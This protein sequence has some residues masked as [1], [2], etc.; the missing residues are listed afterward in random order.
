ME[1]AQAAHEP[2]ER[3]EVRLSIGLFERHRDQSQARRRA[4]AS[5]Q[6]TGAAGRRQRALGF[7]PDCQRELSTPKEIARA[8]NGHEG[9]GTTSPHQVLPAAEPKFYALRQ[10]ASL[11]GANAPHPATLSD[12]T[13]AHYGQLPSSDWTFSISGQRIDLDSTYPAILRGSWLVLSKPSYQEL[14]RASSVT[15]AA[16]AEFHTGRKNH[17]HRTRYQ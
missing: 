8:S 15:E 17:P 5:R 10:R 14:Y 1:L 16:R 6:R 7:S 11:F 13:L 3:A 4:V 12:Q 9:L 2:G